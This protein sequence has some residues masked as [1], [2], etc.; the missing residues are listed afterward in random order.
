[1]TIRER[2]KNGL[3]LFMSLQASK[4]L[5]ISKNLKLRILLNTRH[6]RNEK[7]PLSEAPLVSVV[8]PIYDRTAILVEAIDSVMSQSYQNFELL[9]VLDGSPES[10]EAVAMSYSGDPRVLIHKF[11]SSSGTAVRQRNL[12]I[13]LAKGKYIA[14]LDSD[15]QMH[16]DRLYNSVAALNAGA[17]VVYGAWRAR[18]DGTRSVGQIY[19][20]QLVFS[21]H[22]DYEALLKAC[23]PCQSTVSIRAEIFE[24]IGLIKPELRYR[25]DHELWMRAAYNGAKFEVISEELCT[26]RLHSGNNELNFLD[27]DKHWESMA[28]AKH[29][30]LGPTKIEFL[31][32]IQTGEL[33]V[34]LGFREDA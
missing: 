23:V 6:R 3:T 5:R 17:D 20:G 32:T 4:V 27:E 16:P 2:F 12:A 14:F 13:A 24:K 8:I 34:N 31:E 9:L 7:P 18:L 15:D 26:L 25:E 21:T 29:K 30:L 19:D 1:M 28:I 22:C 11:S 33:T 10:T